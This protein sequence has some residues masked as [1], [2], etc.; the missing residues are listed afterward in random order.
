MT[1]EQI[2][3]QCLS[4]IPLNRGCEYQDVSDLV[5]FLLSDRSSYITG[6]AINFTGGEVVW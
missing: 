5:V 1:R 4:V 3:A 6:Q 2:V